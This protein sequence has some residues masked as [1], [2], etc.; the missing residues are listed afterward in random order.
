MNIPPKAILLAVVVILA[1]GVAG[2]VLSPANT[3]NIIGFCTLTI[4]S[5]VTLLKADTAAVKSDEAATKADAAAAEA[6]AAAAKTA[7]VKE[8]LKQTNIRRKAQLDHIEAT[9][10]KTHTLANA[11]MGAQL[12]LNV[13]ASRRLADLTGE[14]ADMAAANLAEKTLR[15]HEAK[16]AAVDKAS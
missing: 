10:E 3:I 12:R 1:L 7:Q 16:Q 14:P 5:L 2:T 4:T 11:N 6:A 9:G 15:E 8:D 13:I